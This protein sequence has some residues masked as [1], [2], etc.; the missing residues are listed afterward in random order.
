[1]PFPQNSIKGGNQ[2]VAVSHLVLEN[3]FCFWALT[4]LLASEEEKAMFP[5]GQYNSHLTGLWRCEERCP[6]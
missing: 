3:V 1:M 4:S 6:K 2:T 5:Q